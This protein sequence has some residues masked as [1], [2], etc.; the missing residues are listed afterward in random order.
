MYLCG[1]KVAYPSSMRTEASALMTLLDL[2]S[3]LPSSNCILYV[4]Y[5][6]VPGFDSQHMCKNKSFVSFILYCNC[7]YNDSLSSVGHTSKLSDWRG[8][9]VATSEF[10]VQSE[11]RSP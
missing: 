5:K 3:C 4:L 1:R 10:V 2:S 8:R 7:K 6:E 9:V 11:F